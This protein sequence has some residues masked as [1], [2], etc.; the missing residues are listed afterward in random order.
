MLGS[1]EF[2]SIKGGNIY[3]FAPSLTPS[4]PLSYVCVQLPSC[5]R[6]RIITLNYTQNYVVV[7]D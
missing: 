3:Y 2:T 5:I 4:L 7:R 1:H 6:A